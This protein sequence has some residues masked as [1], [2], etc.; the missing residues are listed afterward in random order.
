[1]RRRYSSR[2]ADGE[3]RTSVVGFGI[4]EPHRALERE[5][6]LGVIHQ[7]EH[8][9]LHA[10]EPHVTKAVDDRCRLVEQIRQHDHQ[11]AAA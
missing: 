3:A 1:M 4:A 5:R 8:D 7:V 11:A 9:D 10:A 2:T 6:Q